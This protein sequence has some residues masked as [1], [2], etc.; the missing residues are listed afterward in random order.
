MAWLFSAVKH[1]P[2]PTPATSYPSY[3]VTADIPR[4]QGAGTALLGAVC[5]AIGSDHELAGL[6]CIRKI[7]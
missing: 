2:R 1:P 7:R 4:L 6:K 5:C 3:R